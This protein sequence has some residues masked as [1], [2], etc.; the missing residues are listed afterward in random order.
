MVILMI[1]PLVFDVQDVRCINIT[2]HVVELDLM[3]CALDSVILLKLL[4]NVSAT[5]LIDHH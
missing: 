4:E 3:S 1:V 2:S 5:V